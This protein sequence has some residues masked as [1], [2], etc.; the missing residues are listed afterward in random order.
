VRKVDQTPEPYAPLATAM[1]AFVKLVLERGDD[2]VEKTNE[3]V[4]KA[5][6]NDI[7]LSAVTVS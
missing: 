2:V 7:G 3:T 1:T 5:V 4:L 6:E